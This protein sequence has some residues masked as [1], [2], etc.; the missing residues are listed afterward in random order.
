MTDPRIRQIKIKTGV[1]KRLI[2][3][4]ASYRTEANKQEEK[5]EQLKA[6]AADNFL[7]KQHTASLQET[8][9]MIP[10]SRRRMTVARADLQQLLEAEEELSESAE[11]QEAKSLLDSVPLEAS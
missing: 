7:I 11:Y 5:I 9:M 10:D 2:K 1:L 8:I 6:E 4:E 3:E